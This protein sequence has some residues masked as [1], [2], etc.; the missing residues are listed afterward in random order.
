MRARGVA[1][2]RGLISNCTPPIPPPHPTLC[3]HPMHT[4]LRCVCCTPFI[5]TTPPH[6]V[7]TPLRCVCCTPF[8][9]TTPPHC[10]HTPLRCVLQAVGSQGKGWPL[11]ASRRPQ[12][13]YNSTMGTDP[14]GG[15]EAGSPAPRPRAAHSGTQP[16]TSTFWKR[17]SW[18]RI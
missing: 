12:S 4:P 11:C 16:T 9:S 15:V 17:A 2:S 7:H 14:S 8:I 5:S 3:A 6:C 13:N 18:N 1:S 10:V